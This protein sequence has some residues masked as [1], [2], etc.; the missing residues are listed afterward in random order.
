M[1][2]PTF[3]DMARRAEAGEAEAQ[4]AF[5]A[6]LA[7]RRQMDA[8]RRWLE[9]AAEQGHAD[10]LFTQAGSILTMTEGDVKHRVTALIG[11]RR[12][13]EK[14]SIAALRVLAAL[15]AAGAEGKADW[16]LAIEMMREACEAGDPASMR[17]IAALLLADDANDLDGDAL[18]A[19]AAK[20]DRLAVALLSRRRLR[21]F[22]AADE[23]FSLDRAFD[24]LAD[25]PTALSYRAACEDLCARPRVRAFRRALSVDLCDHL[26]S[27]AL[28]RMKR[29]EVMGPDGRSRPHPHRTA[30]GAGIGFGF[31][32]LPAVLA[33]QHMAN[34]A[35][36]PYDRGEILTVLRY[37]P[38]EEYRP[39]HDFLDA[40][41]P[42][43]AAHG[44]RVR[45]ALLYLN[46]GY[47]GGETHFLS[48]GVKFAGTTG[49]ILVFDNVDGKGAPDI[50]ARHAGMPILRGE[51]W[52][53]TLWF[54][55][56]P[57]SA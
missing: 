52:L 18:M 39:H 8:A 2:A 30:W 14:G 22:A 55:D 31:A 43:L 28:P 5:A 12:A 16:P 48:S 19:E 6:M 40:N 33:G 37:R 13:R 7:E 42:D 11:L 56:R 44:Q 25:A 36:I 27:A 45:T 1:T 4:Y 3:E 35:A 51:K 41:D 53:A 54:R 10:A 9:R 26:I 34:F 50:S 17:E 20:Q 46:D 38:G 47:V 23:R 21:G 32:D 49:D 15:T 24:R 57:F 29:Q